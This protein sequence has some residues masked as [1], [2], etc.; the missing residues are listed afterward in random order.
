[1]SDKIK[2]AIAFAAKG[3]KYAKFGVAL[4]GALV[5]A[6]QQTQDVGGDNVS[7]LVA[8]VTALFVFLTKNKV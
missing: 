6:A 7:L 5:L 1:M 4:A 2:K 3:L 8:L